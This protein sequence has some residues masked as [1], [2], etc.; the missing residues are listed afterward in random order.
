MAQYDEEH[1]KVL[2]QEFT[3]EITAHSNYV[4]ASSVLIPSLIVPVAISQPNGLLLGL[5]AL[6]ILAALPAFYFYTRLY[7]YNQLSGLAKGFLGINGAEE[8]RLYKG[9]ID[10]MPEGTGAIQM[11]VGEL[12]FRLCDARPEAGV[13]DRIEPRSRRIAIKIATRECYELSTRQKQG[14]HWKRILTI[15]WFR[16]G[17]N[18]GPRRG[19][20]WETLRIDESLGERKKSSTNH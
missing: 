19:T 2:L 11:L 13:N 20:Q 8:Q 4:L 7:Y 17:P 1:F 15:G 6:V 9:F 14:K 10:K 3:G 16:G 5:Y 12:Y 18:E